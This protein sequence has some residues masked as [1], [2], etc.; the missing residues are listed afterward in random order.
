MIKLAMIGEQEVDELR[1][2]R[3]FRPCAVNMAL[4]TR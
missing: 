1:Q 3:A 2:F 4:T